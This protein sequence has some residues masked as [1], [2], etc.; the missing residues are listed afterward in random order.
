MEF[1][2]CI[3][4]SWEHS[5]GWN[6]FV[7]ELKTILQIEEELKEICQNVLDILDKNLIPQ[8]TSGESKVFYYKM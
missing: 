8:S 4:I 3:Q 2:T 5:L 6:V 7:H 1:L